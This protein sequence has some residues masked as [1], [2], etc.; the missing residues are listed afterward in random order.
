[1]QLWSLNKD[2]VI[3]LT[4]MI[5]WQQLKTRQQK[6]MLHRLMVQLLNSDIE[7]KMIRVQDSDC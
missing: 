7:P 3:T 5:T 1:M 4:K 2:P 6:T